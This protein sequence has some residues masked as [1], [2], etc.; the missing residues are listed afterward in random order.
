MREIARTDL[1]RIAVEPRVLERLVRDAAEGDGTRVTAVSLSL[2][3][4]GGAAGVSVEASRKA[5]LP[6]LGAAIQERVA[7]ALE[8]LLG[9][10]V[11]V[12]VTIEGVYAEDER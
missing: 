6:E 9:A 12:D 8:S 4:D 11:R 7:A 3:D 2:E 10:P 1:G 5:V